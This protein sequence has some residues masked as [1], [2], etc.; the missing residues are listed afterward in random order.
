[1]HGMVKAKLSFAYFLP[2]CKRT[3]I[4]H[5]GTREKKSDIEAESKLTETIR[6]EITFSVFNFIYG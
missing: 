5:A 6:E 4:V 3:I 2:N 1:M